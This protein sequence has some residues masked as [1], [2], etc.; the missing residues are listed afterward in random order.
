M[1]R[2]IKTALF[3]IISLI[4]LIM[5]SAGGYVLY[6]AD[7]YY[8]IEDNLNLNAENS[9]DLVMS[10]DGTY[11]VITYNIGF[12]AYNHEFSFF[13]D[14][15]RMKDGTEVYGTMSKAENKEVV[16]NNTNGVIS[17][18]EPYNADFY[19]FQEVDTS[20]TR[21][22]YVNQYEMLKGMSQ[23][24]SSVY[25]ANFHS[26]YLLYPLNDFHGKV[27][28]GILTLS[29]YKISNSVRRSFPVDPGFPN[30]F[31]DLDRCFS[32]TRLPLDSG[33]ELVLINLH[34]SAYDKGGTIRAENN[35][36]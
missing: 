18:V 36:G 6:V 24:Y 15:G 12:G 8:R 17:S 14:S 30:R 22:Y 27:L 21:S 19:L 35:K 25:A 16:L 4:T 29:K 28:S 31:F 23:D 5:L 1:K 3:I 2:I 9:K 7:Q 26:A 13:M 10:S 32:V 34:M 33:K 20:S 11:S